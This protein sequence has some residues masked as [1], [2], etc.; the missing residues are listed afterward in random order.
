MRR[1]IAVFIHQRDRPASF[2]LP[3]GRR[4]DTGILMVSTAVKQGLVSKP[5]LLDMKYLTSTISPERGDL[6][7]ANWLYR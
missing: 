3:N 7:C 6:N 5:E 4:L 2:A 1:S